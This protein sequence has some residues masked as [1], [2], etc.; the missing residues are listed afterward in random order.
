[1]NPSP[2]PAGANRA[3][4]PSNIKPSAV[5]GAHRPRAEKSVSFHGQA[6]PL[7]RNDQAL[8]GFPAQKFWSREAGQVTTPAP[9]DGPVFRPRRYC[10]APRE[11]APPW[12][13]DEDPEDVFLENKQMGDC[14][15]AGPQD[16]M[17]PTLALQ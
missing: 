5:I 15:G 7:G 13:Y 10:P 8:G 11:V 2:Q 14:T 12:W 4:A 16:Q 17:A 3:T 9:Y 1:M 6:N